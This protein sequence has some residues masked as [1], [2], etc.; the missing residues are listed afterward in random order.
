MKLKR[1]QCTLIACLFCVTNND[2]LPDRFEE[3]DGVSLEAN[4]TLV[5]GCSEDPLLLLV[6][7]GREELD[8]GVAHDFVPRAQVLSSINNDPLSFATCK[9]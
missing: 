3:V 5:P 6:G 7:P 1:P 8:G 4:D 2:D 9:Q